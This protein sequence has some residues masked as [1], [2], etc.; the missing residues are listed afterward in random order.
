VYIMVKA[1]VMSKQERVG[2]GGGGGDIEEWERG[3][4]HFD[5]EV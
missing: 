3:Y 1:E 2:R 4:V 5:P